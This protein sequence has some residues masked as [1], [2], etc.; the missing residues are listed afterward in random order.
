MGGEG[1][2]ERE[3]L[4]KG[5]EQRL[6]DLARDQVQANPLTPTPGQTGSGSLVAQAK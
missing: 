1:E 3:G 5:L 4:G 6:E 2:W